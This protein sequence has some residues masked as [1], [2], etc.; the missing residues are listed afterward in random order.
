MRR[1][2]CTEEL[3]KIW[4]KTESKEI[5]GCENVH[6]VRN[7]DGKIFPSCFLNEAKAEAAV[8]PVRGDAENHHS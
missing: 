5:C 3:R 2:S 4:Q 7:K 1:M 8:I 6:A